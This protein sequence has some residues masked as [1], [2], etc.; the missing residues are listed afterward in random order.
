MG[1]W[2][3]LTCSG[4]GPLLARMP[5]RIWQELWSSETHRLT[6]SISVYGLICQRSSGRVYP[7][8]SM[9]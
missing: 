1:V 5:P 9:R 4:P 6:R 2:T 3:R 7:D 8:L